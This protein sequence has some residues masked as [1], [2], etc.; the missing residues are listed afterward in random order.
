LGKDLLNNC[1]FLAN[2]SNFYSSRIERE[3]GFLLGVE[4]FK[5][6]KSLPNSERPT[7]EV[8]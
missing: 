7:F 6:E 1:P 3:I 5:K 4:G 8:A 2:I